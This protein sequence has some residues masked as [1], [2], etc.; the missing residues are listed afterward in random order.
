MDR[1]STRVLENAAP[2]REQEL[3][4]ATGAN[5]ATISAFFGKKSKARKAQI[6]EILE[7][8]RSLGKLE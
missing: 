1:G 8:L 7:T 3:L 2:D 6:T 4:P 5:A